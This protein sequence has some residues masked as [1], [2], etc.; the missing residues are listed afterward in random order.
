MCVW[1]AHQ[2]LCGCAFLAPC[3]PAAASLLLVVVAVSVMVSHAAGIWVSRMEGL[4]PLVAPAMITMMGS[5]A[6][7]LMSQAMPAASLVRQAV[8]RAQQT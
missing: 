5:L 2:L 1:A 8:S 7:L 4:L 6:L 3:L